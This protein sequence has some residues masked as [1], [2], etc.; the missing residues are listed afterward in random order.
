M[1]YIKVIQRN[2][3]TRELIPRSQRRLGTWIIT[4]LAYS[5]ALESKVVCSKSEMRMFYLLAMRFNEKPQKHPGN[6]ASGQ[7]E[8]TMSKEMISQPMVGSVEP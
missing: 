7:W 3:D 4:T 6:E 2:K 5:L 1:K 8:A